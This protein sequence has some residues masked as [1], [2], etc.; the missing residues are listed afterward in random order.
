MPDGGLRCVV[1][2]PERAVLDE[3]VDFYW[4]SMGKNIQ[5]VEES[6]W[7]YF[8]CPQPQAKVAAI[9]REK[10]PEPPLYWQEVL[11]VDQEPASLGV[12]FFDPSQSWLYVWFVFDPKSKEFSYLVMARGKHGLSGDWAC[13]LY[14]EWR[15]GTLRN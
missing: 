14:D 12:Y 9:H 11:W 10:L 5:K 4:P 2:T 15:G 7:G 13:W 8:F 6:S 3:P 1:V